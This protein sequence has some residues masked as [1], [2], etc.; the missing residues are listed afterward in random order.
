MFRSTKRDKN[1]YYA[2]L[3]AT[4]NEKACYVLKRTAKYIRSK[5]FLFNIQ[6]NEFPISR[7]FFNT[8]MRTLT[9]TNLILRLHNSALYCYIV[10]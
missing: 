5:L 1:S 9:Q 3:D 8:P 7:T 6:H 10:T 4:N 2:L